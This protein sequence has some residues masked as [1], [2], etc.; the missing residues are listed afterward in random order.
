MTQQKK[1][2]N[3]V[4]TVELRFLGEPS[5]ISDRL[6]LKPSNS[7]S[8]KQNQKMKRPRRPYWGYSGRGEAGYLRKWE[9]LGDGLKFLLE[10][11]RACE[12]MLAQILL[13]IFRGRR[14]HKPGCTGDH[15]APRCLKSERIRP[16]RRTLEPLVGQGRLGCVVFIAEIEK[17]TRSEIQK[18]RNHC[19]WPSVRWTLVVRSLPIQL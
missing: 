3:H 7:F 18:I 11:L 19:H 8:K 1:V 6:N 9:S 12:N 2:P 4:Y 17:F 5:E 16:K 10:I 13:L 14:H 15:G